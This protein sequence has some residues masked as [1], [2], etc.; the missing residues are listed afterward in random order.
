MK[1]IKMN[2]LIIILFLIFSISKSKEILEEWEYNTQNKIENSTFISFAINNIT[3]TKIYVDKDYLYIIK[4]D[5]EYTISHNKEITS[6]NSPLIEYNQDYYFC[7]NLNLYKI[8]N[9]NSQLEK[10]EFNSNSS[11]TIKSLKCNK[12]STYNSEYIFVGLIGTNSIFTYRLSDNKTNCQQLSGEIIAISSYNIDT[13]ISHHAIFYKNYADNKYILQIFKCENNDALNPIHQSILSDYS[14]FEF[15]DNSTIKISFLTDKNIL[16]IS[17]IKDQELHFYHFDFGGNILQLVGGNSVL[18]SFNQYTV[19]NADF[20]ENT[21]YIY[22]IIERAGRFY[23][24]VADLQYYII[25]YNI[26]IPE[27][28]NITYDEGYFYQSKL[29]LNYFEGTNHKLVCPFVLNSTLCQ[30]EL[31]GKYLTIS[32]EYSFNLMVKL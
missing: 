18:R 22:Y 7:T 11:D 19:I 28:L 14:N 27:G 12:M 20:L 31:E 32:N 21:P 13:E 30:H 1:S 9:E 6:I 4:K 16:I 8:R 10:I 15:T 3:D 23:L 25:V 24:G 17:Y 29:F 2:L 26:E 5:E